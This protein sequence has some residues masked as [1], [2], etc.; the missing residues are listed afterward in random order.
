YPEGNYQLRAAIAREH[1]EYVQGFL[2]YLAT[3]PHV[4]KGLH[5]VLAP[6]GLCKDEFTD[7][8]N[9]PYQLYIREARRMRG[10]FVM[11]QRDIQREVTKRDAI[12]M[13][14]YNSDSHNVQR[15][16][17]PD[18]AVENEGDVEVPVKPYQI[19]YR[20]LLPK[21]RQAVNLLVPVAVSA[22][23]IAYATLRMEP[24]FMIMGQAA[25]VA[26]T[27]AH[28]TGVPVQDI[29]IALLASRLHAQ[30]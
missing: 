29:D 9:W 24:Q 27:L 13:G 17:T 22:T 19:P 21:R 7:N 6:W 4:P 15:V 23:H 11:S 16:V 5:D 25:G 26:A 28:E 1:L 12:G 20:I 8:G 2:Y 10:A 3:D 18:G 30:A 14:S